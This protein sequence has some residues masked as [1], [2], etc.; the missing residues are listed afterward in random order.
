ML[1]LFASFIAH[2]TRSNENQ[3]HFTILEKF[4]NKDWVHLFSNKYILSKYWFKLNFEIKLEFF[5][6]YSSIIIEIW[7]LKLDLEN[8]KIKLKYQVFKY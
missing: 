8:E 3:F 1:R 5:I 7:H 2:E 4:L 6:I